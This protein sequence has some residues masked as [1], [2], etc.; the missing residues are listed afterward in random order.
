[1]FDFINQYRFFCLSTTF[2]HFYCQLENQ[3]SNTLHWRLR[4]TQNNTSAIIHMTYRITR[5]DLVARVPATES[6][7]VFL[8][9]IWMIDDV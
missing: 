4:E 3:A 1:M 6:L 7:S 8:Y 2:S 9:V 5:S